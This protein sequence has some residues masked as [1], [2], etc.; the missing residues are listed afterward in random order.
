MGFRSLLL[1]AA[2]S[3]IALGI[4][5]CSSTTAPSV[6]LTGT[7]GLVSIQFGQG[8]TALSPPTE[9]GNFALSTTTYNLSLTGAVPETDAGTYAANGTSWSQVS[10][11]SGVQS[12]GTYTLSGTTLTVTTVQSGVTVV[13]VWQKL[14]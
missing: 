9:E 3:A 5:G 7:Y 13:A 10:S 11:T 6:D 4:T 14:S 2:G 12:T 8:T 1:L